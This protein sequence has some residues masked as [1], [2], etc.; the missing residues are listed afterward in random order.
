MW[1]GP[2][3]RYGRAVADNA[4]T[5]KYSPATPVKACWSRGVA[6]CV[7]APDRRGRYAAKGVECAVTKGRGHPVAGGAN[8]QTA[9]EQDWSEGVPRA[10]H[11]R[12]KVVAGLDEAISLPS[13]GRRHHTDAIITTTMCTPSVSCARSIRPA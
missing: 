4:K 8:L 13:A 12:P 11:Q 7:S 1:D 6:G 5:Q 3:H 2:R 10:H 9:T